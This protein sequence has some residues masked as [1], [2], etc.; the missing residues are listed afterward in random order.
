MEVRARKRISERN[1][2]SYITSC[3]TFLPFISVPVPACGGAPPAPAQLLTDA[4]GCKAGR[5]AAHLPRA[6]QPPPGRQGA[7]VARPTGRRP[8]PRPAYRKEADALP[9]PAPVS[10]GGPAHAATGCGELGEAAA[11]FFPGNH[12]GGILAWARSFLA[13]SL[14]AESLPPQAQPRGYPGCDPGQGASPLFV[15]GCGALRPPLVG[16]GTK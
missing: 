14:W 10:H 1:K 7:R 5:L 15:T 9:R 13:L 12:Q 6:V 3:G 8:T 4:G 16:G 11:I 2:Y